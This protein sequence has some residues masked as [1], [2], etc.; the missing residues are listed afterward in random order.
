MFFSEGGARDIP[1]FVV[2]TGEGPT[3][4]DTETKDIRASVLKC[5]I[6][7]SVEKNE[8]FDAS[9]P[10]QQPMHP[11]LRTRDVGPADYVIDNRSEG[12]VDEKYL[13]QQSLGSGQYGFAVVAKHKVESKVYCCKTISKR[14]LDAYELDGL[15]REVQIMRHLYGHPNIV[16][17]K[18]VFEDNS[19]VHIV[20][21]CHMGGDLV[22][23]ANEL[24]KMSEKIAARTFHGIMVAIQQCHDYGVVHRDIKLD[25][26]LLSDKSEEARPILVDF[27]T[28]TW[29]KPGQILREPVGTP[30]YVAP[31]VLKQNYGR[32][33]DLWSAGVLLYIMLSGYG[34]FGGTDENQLFASVLAG[35]FDL[36][37]EPWPDIS[38]SAKDLLS[39]L[40]VVNPKER[41]TAVQALEHPWVANAASNSDHPL[42]DSV[43][44]RLKKFG[45]MNE[46][47]KAGRA[48]ISK[49][50][51][52]FELEGLKQL[53]AIFDVSKNGRITLAQLQLGLKK[54]GF[55]LLH[56][57]V[58]DILN[59][60]DVSNDHTIDY[61]EFVSAMLPA[62]LVHSHDK[63]W[64][65]FRAFD[66]DSDGF[67]T[68]EEIENVL[69]KQGVSKVDIEKI[70]KEVDENGDGVINFDEFA[71]QFT[72]K[73]KVVFK[74]AQRKAMNVDVDNI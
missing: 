62:S 25:N 53:F 19:N 27:G 31:E 71:S 48:V 24:G 10:R 47:M 66:E 70:V 42:D 51:V 35:T 17:F 52:P 56:D 29:Y 50:L 38:D 36:S 23:R 74:A 26:V 41:L 12:T 69:A 67:I 43:I 60:I 14:I 18:E 54:L 9:V 61:N 20:M 64:E 30:L 45:A 6:S 72:R 2:Q 39:R 8:N 57:Q 73:Q 11:K 55:D 13:L 33:V 34:P 46:F 65:A 37:S 59:G 40:L 1:A 3:K 44:M 49:K 63:V 21:D 7:E 5:D 16:D 28:A 68:F 15:R 4:D 22:A 58:E 32:E